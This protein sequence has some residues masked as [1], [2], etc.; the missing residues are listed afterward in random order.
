MSESCTKEYLYFDMLGF[1]VMASNRIKSGLQVT[2]SDGSSASDH[3]TVLYLDPV[4]ATPRGPPIR[5]QNH[6]FYVNMS[7]YEPK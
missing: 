5:P 1:G 7:P 2:E 4:H 6:R 3:A